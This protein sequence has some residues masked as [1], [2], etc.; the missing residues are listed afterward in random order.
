MFEYLLD[1]VFGVD[2]TWCL[3]DEYGEPL[4]CGNFNTGKAVAIY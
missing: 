3:T 1:R 2:G 4:Y